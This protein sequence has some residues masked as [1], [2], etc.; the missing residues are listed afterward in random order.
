MLVRMFVIELLI[1]ANTSFKLN[2][3][4]TVL[5]GR[6]NNY[7]F[8]FTPAISMFLGISSNYGFI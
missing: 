4:Q 3:I 8:V 1:A 5:L 7:V 6:N 2:L